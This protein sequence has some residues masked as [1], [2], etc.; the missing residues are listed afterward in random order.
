VILVFCLDE[1]CAIDKLSDNR[2]WLNYILFLM[3]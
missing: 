2:K 1:K 3:Q